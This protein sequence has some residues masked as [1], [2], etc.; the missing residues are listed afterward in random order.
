MGLD[1]RDCIVQPKS[2]ANWRQEEPW[3]EERP[4]VNVLMVGHHEPYEPRGSRTVLG[5]PGG[6][7]P[8]GDST[9]GTVRD[10]HFSRQL[11]PLTADMKS[12]KSNNRTNDFRL[13]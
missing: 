7:I 2:K 8:P 12:V 4:L 9:K 1:Q 11:W 5:A 6:E 13:S 10:G 3:D